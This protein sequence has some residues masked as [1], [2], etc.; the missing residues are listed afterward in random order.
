MVTSAPVRT[1]PKSLQGGGYSKKMKSA[2]HH[3]RMPLWDRKAYIAY[4]MVTPAPKSLL[5]LQDKSEK[6][7][8]RIIKISHKPPVSYKIFQ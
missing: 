8:P 1:A 7:I 4:K 6:L 5:G 3:A 2:L